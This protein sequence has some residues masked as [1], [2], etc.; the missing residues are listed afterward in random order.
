MGPP[1]PCGVH[2]TND[3]C[4][5]NYNEEELVGEKGGGNL[6]KEENEKDHNNYVWL[7]LPLNY[8]TDH[9]ILPKIL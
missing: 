1:I 4:G 5:N 9:L 8:T 3:E 6:K 7:I 2:H